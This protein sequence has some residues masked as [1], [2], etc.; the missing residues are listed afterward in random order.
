MAPLGLIA[1]GLLGLVGVLVIVLV[2]TPLHLALRA[3]AG[4]ATRMEV[5]A[6]TFWGLSPALRLPVG[7]KL[8]RRGREERKRRR[9]WAGWRSAGW[10]GK[11]FA[12]PRLSSLRALLDPIS[13]DRLELDLRFGTGDPAETGQ[14]YGYLTAL[15]FALPVHTGAIR[16][17]PDFDTAVIEPRGEA[18]LHFTPLA[19]VM[20]TI[21]ILRDIGGR[22]A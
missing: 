18:R 9:K 4:G 1:A 15:A 21:R 11:G 19:L 10:R 6:R 12:L 20:P 8:R 13:L 2:A 16:L 14:L 17:R 5:S 22:R 3:Q 7:E